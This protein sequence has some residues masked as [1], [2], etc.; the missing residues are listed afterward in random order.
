MMIRCTNIIL[1][2]QQGD[3]LWPCLL[4]VIYSIYPSSQFGTLYNIHIHV[5]RKQLKFVMSAAAAPGGVAPH[6]IRIKRFK[7]TIFLHCDVHHDTVQALKERVEKLTGR[8]WMQ[9]RLLLGKQNLDNFS[10]LYDC[11]I[12][13]EDG[14]LNMTYLLSVS[15]GGEEVWEDLEDAL[16]GTTENAAG[17]GSGV[18]DGAAA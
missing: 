1:V 9:I 16:L 18:T 4:R 12:E 6:Y 5:P 8:P 7:Q 3:T 10:T 11:G 15:A 2:K 13:A 17:Q 14:E